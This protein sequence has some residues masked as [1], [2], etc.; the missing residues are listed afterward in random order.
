MRTENPQ[1]FIWHEEILFIVK[2]IRWA[3]FAEPIVPY[4]LSLLG[5]IEEDDNPD[6]ASSLSILS[7]IFIIWIFKFNSMRLYCRAFD[8]NCSDDFGCAKKNSNDPH[9]IEIL[10][11]LS[12]IWTWTSSEFFLYLKKIFFF[13][14]WGCHLWRI[15]NLRNANEFREKKTLEYTCTVLPCT[16][17]YL[18]FSQCFND[19]TKRL[20]HFNKELNSLST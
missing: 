15:A 19:K 18:K 3:F 11:I 4:T 7:S 16:V 1:L 8:E 20:M 12:W 6:P 9:T 13:L 5:L 17:Y 2:Y 10:A 14:L